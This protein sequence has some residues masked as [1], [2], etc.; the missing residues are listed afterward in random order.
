M[1][2]IHQVVGVLSDPVALLLFGILLGAVCLRR[3]FLLMVFGM[4][5]IC[6]MPLTNGWI[7]Q[8]LEKPFPPARA[9]EMP[10]TAAILVLGGGIGLPEAPCRLPYADLSEAGDRVWHAAR[11]YHAG[12]ASKVYC[13]NRD[14]SRTTP[15][16]LKDLG[17]PHDSIVPLDGPRNTEEEARRCAAELGEQRVLL[18]TSAAHMRRAVNIFR[19][20]A[21]T[22]DVVPAA[23]DYKGVGS[24]VWKFN[25]RR[26][27]PSASALSQF[28][29][30][31]H[32]LFGLVRYAF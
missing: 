32:E 17:V 20:Y 29:Q 2:V 7:V 3:W 23:T 27:L 10:Q 15:Q 21:P 1:F 19:K 22:L 4:A 18:V 28:N 13:T 26:Y 12:R 14:V 5:W 24:D 8:W 11:L 30:S 16:F 9:E 31:L 25:I 6:S